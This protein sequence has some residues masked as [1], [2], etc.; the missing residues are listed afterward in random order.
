MRDVINFQ[1]FANRAP[2]DTF[3][4]YDDDNDLI[5]GAAPDPLITTTGT[6]QGG[7]A[8]IRCFVATRDHPVSLNLT[9][10]LPVYIEL[11]EENGIVQYGR[12]TT[13]PPVMT[14]VNQ[15]YYFPMNKRYD[16]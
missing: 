3:P 5:G 10:D 9:A 7:V 4:L 6:L 16:E 13:V 2:K 1:I 12:V 8:C 11:I 14:R 15:Q